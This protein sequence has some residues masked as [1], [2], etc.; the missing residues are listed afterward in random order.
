M[1]FLVDAQLPRRLI[2]P[3]RD[4][5]HDA[6]HTLDLPKG[7]RTP[8]A[9]ITQLSVSEERVVVT[10][11]SDFVD[12]LIVH[13]V[14]HK[15]LLVS[16]GNIRNSALETLLFKNLEAIVDGFSDHDFIEIERTALR[17]HY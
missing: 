9:A 8:D 5:G 12:S 2:Y 13:G 11:D 3:L 16:T 14:P 17:F 7:N 6:V 1:K 15:L 10:K 4:R